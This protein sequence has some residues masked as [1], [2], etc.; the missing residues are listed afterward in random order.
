L[1]EFE[2]KAWAVCRLPISSDKYLETL[3]DALTLEAEK[4]VSTRARTMIKREGKFL[5]LKV[6][7]NDSVALRA[8]FNAYLSWINSTLKVLQVIEHSKNTAVV[9]G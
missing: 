4:P 5:V 1:E 2:L 9:C 7:A 3:L 8:A 6:T